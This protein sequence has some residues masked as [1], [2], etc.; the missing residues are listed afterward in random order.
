[1]KFIWIDVRGAFSLL[2]P[3]VSAIFSDN[4]LATPAVT[5]DVIFGPLKL[6]INK[7]LESHYSGVQE[8]FILRLVDALSLILPRGGERFR[9]SLCGQTEMF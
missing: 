1:M 8:C 5:G 7:I 2:L 3:I 4:E 6:A 9:K